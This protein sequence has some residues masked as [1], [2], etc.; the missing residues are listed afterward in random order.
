[1]EFAIFPGVG[2]VNTFTIDTL[3]RIVTFN[4]AI[5]YCLGSGVL[6][7]V[8]FPGGNMLYRRITKQ[9]EIYLDTCKTLIFLF[10]REDV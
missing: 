6:P 2:H 7:L 3:R 4:S 1:M 9:D 5:I 8:C 10:Y